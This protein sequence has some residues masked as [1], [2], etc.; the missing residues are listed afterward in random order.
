M[1]GN[2]A[3]QEHYKSTNTRFAHGGVTQPKVSSKKT[4]APQKLEKLITMRQKHRKALHSH[5]LA[6]CAP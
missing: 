3:L 5:M 4:V 2:K 1:S 6:G